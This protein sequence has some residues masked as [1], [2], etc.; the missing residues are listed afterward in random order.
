VL[1]NLSRLG[2]CDRNDH[3]FHIVCHPRSLC[4]VPS[5]CIRV[6]TYRD[7]LQIQA[8]KDAVQECTNGPST[9]PGICDNFE[10]SAHDTKRLKPF[11]SHREA[12]TAAEAVSFG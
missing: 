5:P 4:A 12:H 9:C 3:L 2:H 8:Y 7:A 10:P 1:M 11:L 6:L